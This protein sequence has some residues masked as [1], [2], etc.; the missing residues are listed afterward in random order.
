MTMDY[1]TAGVCSDCA[2]FANLKYDCPYIDA[3]LKM[4]RHIKS[5]CDIHSE[6]KSVCVSVG[7]NN[8]VPSHK[9]PFI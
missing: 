2:N 7:C 9:N 5:I 6:L 8:F 1:I 3:M 4:S